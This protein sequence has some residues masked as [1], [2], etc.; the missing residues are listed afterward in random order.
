[1][2][3]S[4]LKGKQTP[5]KWY[6][7]TNHTYEEP[8]TTAS[9]D[10]DW[11]TYVNAESA[12][13]YCPIRGSGPDVVTA[14]ANATI[15]AEAGTVANETGMW[16]LDMVERIKELEEVLQ[17]AVNAWDDGDLDGAIIRRLRTVL[18]EAT[19]KAI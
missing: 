12:T 13:M 18:R 6:L 11:N 16:P 5:G 3:R 7:P 8:G 17:D 10:G 2:E 9:G 1:M 4:E 14:E 19:E 15:A